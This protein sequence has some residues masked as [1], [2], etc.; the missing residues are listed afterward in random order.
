LAAA[1]LIESRQ[2]IVNGSVL[3]GRLTVRM[4]DTILAVAPMHLAL[5]CAHSDSPVVTETLAV[6]Q[7]ALRLEAS[8]HQLGKLFLD[9]GLDKDFG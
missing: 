2:Q 7:R 5:V 1:L 3:L 8:L 6:P 9:D 4:L